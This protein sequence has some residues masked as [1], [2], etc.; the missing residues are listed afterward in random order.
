[1]RW[2]CQSRYRR[3]AHSAPP[4]PHR[5]ALE[6]LYR[7]RHHE[8]ARAAQ[9]QARRSRW[10]VCQRPASARRRDHDCAGALAQCRADARRRRFRP[11][12]R[13]PSLS[14]RERASRR[15]KAAS[16]DRARHAVQIF[17]PRLCP[18]GPRHR[19]GDQGALLHLDQARDRRACGPARD[20][21]ECAASQGRA[22]CARPYAEAAARRALCD[23]RR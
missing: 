18:D 4:L 9:A 15:V 6:E 23:P 10:S 21:A 14:R 16:R 1:M 5:L 7:G 13:Q 2:P 17:Q 11:V 3:E 8:A 22:A 19:S 12:H 20:R